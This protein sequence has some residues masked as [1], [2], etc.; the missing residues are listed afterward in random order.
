MKLVVAEKPSVAADIA[1]ALGVTNKKKG[2]IEGNGYIVTWCVGHLIELAYPEDYAPELKKWELET[3][4]FIPTEW[5]YNVSEA[6]KEQFKIVK[7]LMHKPEVTVVINSG[8]AGREGELIFRLVYNYAKCKKPVQRLWINSIEEEVIRAGFQNLKPGS[9]YDNLYF[10]ALNRMQS[11]YLVGINATRLFTVLYNQTLNVGRVQSPTINLIVERQKAIENF[12]PMP[13][14]ILKANC[15]GFIATKRVETAESA[16][17]IIR[18]CNGQIGTVK[19]LSQKPTKENPPNLFD[20]TT[21]QREANTKLGLTAQ[22]TLNVAQS[23]Y[24]KKLITY[25]RTDSSFITTDMIEST[26]KVLE[27]TLNLSSLN[28]QT[29]SNFNLSVAN[30]EKLA[31]NKKVS[32]HHALLPTVKVNDVNF[33]QLNA[34]EKNVLLLI[35]YKLLVA[36]YT[37]HEYIKT[38]VIVSIDGEEFKATGKQITVEG[39]KEIEQQ[40][41]QLLKATED[42]KDKEVT[43]LPELSEG[44][45]IRKITLS[46]ESKK[47]KPPKPYT[48]NTLL[49][50]MENVM[51]TLE[52]EDLRKELKQ[53]GL[54]TSATRAGIIERIIKS[55]FIERK[56]TTLLPTDKAKNLI[57]VIP[58]KIKSPLLTAEWEQQ[59][60][61]IRRGEFNH[62]QFMTDIS[63]FVEGLVNEYKDKEI[64]AELFK[65]DTQPTEKEV[66]GK[67]PRCGKNIYENNKSFYCE[68]YKDSPACKFSLWKEDKFFKTRNKKITKTAAKSLLKNGH[69]DMKD[70]TA[71]NG[72]KY[73]ARFIMQDS[74]QFIN[75]KMEFI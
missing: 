55:G 1:A 9:E 44:Q 5:K 24:E 19:N 71:K 30:V 14:F 25:P 53:K 34:N 70:L 74:N 73:N 75:F 48:E 54:G 46:S 20:L 38:D 69:V 41:Q 42:K 31:N 40:L 52:D 68:G 28:E 63:C 62:M 16:D 4:P 65:I 26:K 66:I 29:N 67:C 47:T 72:N 17:E 2:F 43:I 49:G 8:D 6:A 36:T 45:I 13:Y 57:E 12:V 35:I 3:L 60:E 23:L 22:E 58:E 18:R 27:N 61:A 50:A 37:P 7:E 32:D 33:E 10:A 64:D 11:D 21:L 51:S 56:G 59:L 15:D 39:Y